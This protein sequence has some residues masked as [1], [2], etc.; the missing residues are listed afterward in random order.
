M[1]IQFLWH[2]FFKI[3]FKGATFIVDPFI[4]VP[5][6]EATFKPCMHCPV[7]VSKIRGINFVCVSNEQ[8]DHFDR[9]CI[10]LIA[11][12]DK[13]T[14]VA[15]DSVLNELN[16][17][18][19]LKHPVKIGDSFMLNGVTIEIKNAH[20]PN[21]FYPLSFLF[22][23]DGESVFFAGNT[24][25]MDSFAEIKSDVAILP[26]GGS[27]TMDIIDA[28]RATKTMKPKYVIPM[29]Y[30]SF[31]TIMADPNEF[32]SRIEKSVLKTIPVVLPPGGFFKTE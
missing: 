6:G 7:D 28:V 24:D 5:D 11:E 19:S 4:D 20:C 14:V 17:P 16:M 3:S 27:S 30:N 18:P 26:I 13:S 12:R 21:S 9:K 23:K 10:E 8:F 32:K 1:K 29:H 25:L 15:H 2:S 22:S 31:S